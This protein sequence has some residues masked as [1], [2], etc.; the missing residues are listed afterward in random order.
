[1]SS[2]G[3]DLA[4]I[5]IHLNFTL[6]DIHQKT[7]IPLETLKRIEDGS[8]FT[9][10]DENQTYIRGFVR[11][12]AK[13]LKLSEEMTLKALNQQENGNY[14]QLLLEP[15]PKLNQGIAP[16][17][18]VHEKDK[19]SSGRSDSK[20]AGT[21]A[22]GS[23]SD[24]KEA[25][26]TVSGSRTGEKHDTES[27][28]S[29]LQ[30]EIPT[31]SGGKPDDGEAERKQSDINTGS[32]KSGSEKSE[33]GEP[34]SRELAS[35][36]S[37]RSESDS[38]SSA[39]KSESAPGSRKSEDNAGSRSTLQSSEDTESSDAKSPAS[40]KI[41]TEGTSESEPKSGDKEVD[42][43]ELGH[44]FHQQ[45][46]K[47]PVWIIGTVIFLIIVLVSAYLLY[48]NDFFAGDNHTLQEE[49]LDLPTETATG[50]AASTDLGID[51]TT[52][53]P[54]SDA[55]PPPLDETLYLT[56]YAAYDKLEPVR[57]WSDTK[58]E[59]DPYWI[60]QGEAWNFEF[61]D[62][63]RVRAPYDRLLLFLNGHRIDNLNRDHFNE[64]QNAIELTRN[65]FQQDDEWAEPVPFDLPEETAEPDTVLL[66]PSF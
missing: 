23:S 39:G 19:T 63:I 32:E 5:R 36:Q 10:S 22:P 42:W 7:R 8:I 2:L 27:E 21:T 54:D 48:S 25:G 11:S 43:A 58:P 40:E 14:N 4:T 9:D 65:F 51:L 52:E 37:G 1:M 59:F 56:V 62:T 49:E 30:S 34:D 60:E 18:P 13:A 20:R 41:A 45:Q 33:S 15:F 17:R 26:T 46:K 47:T 38:S 31:D 24:D 6:E 28:K 61:R 66:R 3:Q 12:Y 64:H 57:V 35:D 50:Q 16:P 44:R 53:S 55:A 29:R